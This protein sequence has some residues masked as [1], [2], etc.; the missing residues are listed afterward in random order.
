MPSMPDVMIV[1]RPGEDVCA[2][3]RSAQVV[4]IDANVGRAPPDDRQATSEV[5][6]PALSMMAFQASERTEFGQM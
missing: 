6:F 3:L 4:D 5:V 2:A 1:E